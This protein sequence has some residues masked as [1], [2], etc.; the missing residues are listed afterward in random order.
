MSYVKQ[1]P[2]I[3]IYIYEDVWTIEEKT[4]TFRLKRRAKSA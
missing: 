1:T 3:F 2:K 4:R